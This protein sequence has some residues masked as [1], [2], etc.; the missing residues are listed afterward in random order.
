MKEDIL[1]LENLKNREEIIKSFINENSFS[2]YLYNIFEKYLDLYS[3][4]E[5]D[6]LDNLLGAD[7]I[8]RIEKHIKEMQIVKDEFLL[9]LFFLILKEGA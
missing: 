7:S 8:S 6:F 3:N 1:C 5:K 2:S 4:Y 9:N